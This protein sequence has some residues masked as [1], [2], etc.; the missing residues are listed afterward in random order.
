M[1]LFRLM[2]QRI[3]V[4]H[5]VLREQITGIRVVRAFVREPLERERFGA[6]NDDLTQTALRVGRLQA[7]LFPTVLLVLNVSSVAVLWFGG[8]RVGAGEMQI[9]S[10]TAFLSYLMQ[11]LMAILMATFMLVSYPP[12]AV[13]ADRVQEVLT[14]ESSG[15]PP[16]RSADDHVRTG[17]R[18]AAGRGVALPGRRRPCA[19]G[20][21]LHRQAGTGH[22]HRREHRFKQDDLALPDP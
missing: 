9:G 18:R 21:L 2:Q 1:P 4:V 10:L 6:A 19:P 16:D 15:L 7:F 13:S 11:I 8:H 14:T 20:H 17:D 3:D 5:R 12:A 22:R